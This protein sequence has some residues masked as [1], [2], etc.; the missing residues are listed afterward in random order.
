MYMYLLHTYGTSRIM[1][2]ANLNGYS[3][4]HKNPQ[5]NK[6]Y[7]NG[8]YHLNL[9]NFIFDLIKG[10]YIYFTNLENKPEQ[11]LKEYVERSKEFLTVFGPL[12][13]QYFTNYGAID[14]ILSCLDS[15]DINWSI[16][17]NEIYKLCLSK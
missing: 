8:V 6:I 17:E 16:L 12:G 10:T 15:K 7:L 14:L 9:S 5:A 2:D 11:E 4:T 1:K 3:F 13:E